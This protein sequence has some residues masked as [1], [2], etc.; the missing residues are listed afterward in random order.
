[1][2]N[3]ESSRRPIDAVMAEHDRMHQSP[4]NKT[5]QWVYIPLLTFG[6]L[7]IIWAVPFP[8]LDFLGKYNGFVNWAS[9]LIAFSIYYYYTLSPVLSYGILLMIFAS[10]AVIV[11]LEKLH[12]NH[13]WPLLGI[14]CAGI[15]LVGLVFQLIGFRKEAKVPSFTTYIKSLLT[16]P[17][18]L[19]Y[20]AFKKAGF[21]G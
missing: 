3:K 11:G 7:G 20:L 14:V 6:L 5:L 8:H 21:R 9:F 16:S 18:V 17:I 15:F 12:S 2:A 1:M 13:N 4:I 19:M 10:S